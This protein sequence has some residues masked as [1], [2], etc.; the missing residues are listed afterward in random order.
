M[1][2]NH[3]RRLL[4]SL[5]SARSRNPIEPLSVLQRDPGALFEGNPLD[6]R[7]LLADVADISGVVPLPPVPK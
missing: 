1:V 6:L 3:H 2:V 5:P 4:I 7:Q